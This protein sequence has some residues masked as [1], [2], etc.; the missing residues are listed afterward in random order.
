M[1]KYVFVAN[2]NNKIGSEVVKKLISENFI[3]FA[4]DVSYENKKFGNLIYVNLD[5]SSY[6]SLET[7]KRYIQKYTSRIFAIVNISKYITFSPLIEC[8]E[9]EVLKSIELNFLSAFRTNQVLWDILEQKS[10][11][12]IHDCSDVS[13]YELAPFNGVYSIAKSMLKNYNDVLRRELKEKGIS[14]VRV[15]TGLIKDDNYENITD[16]YHKVS[17]K[18]KIFFGEMS[19]FINLNISKG[20]LVNVYDYCDFLVRVVKSKILKKTYYFKVNKKLR[21]ISMLPRPLRDMYFKGYQK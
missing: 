19:R 9:E 10:G 18:S 16:S 20:S 1:D 21:F 7:A 14:V 12:I 2:A 15:H 6:K 5:T 3:V 8:E 17:E 11:R 4:G 13:I